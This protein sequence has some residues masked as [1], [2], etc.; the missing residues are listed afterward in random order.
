MIDD[1]FEIFNATGI[2]NGIETALN[3]DSEVLLNIVYEWMDYNDYDAIMKEFHADN[4]YK[5][6]K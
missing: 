1:E 5:E 2:I 3:C 6:I 4:K